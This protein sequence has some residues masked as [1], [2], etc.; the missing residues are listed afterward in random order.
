MI[1]PAPRYYETCVFKLDE[2][3]KATDM[4]A[5]VDSGN[6]PIKAVDDHMKLC[7]QMHTKIMQD[8]VEDITQG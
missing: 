8:E 3:M 4:L 7:L 6:D 2:N 1:I 5:Q